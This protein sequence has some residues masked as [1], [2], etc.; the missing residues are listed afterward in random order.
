MS[1]S[2]PPP[3]KINPHSSAESVYKQWVFKSAISR[4][5]VCNNCSSEATPAGKLYVQQAGTIPQLPFKICVLIVKV[6][7]K[8]KLTFSYLV[9]FEGCPD[10]E[11]DLGCRGLGNVT[12]S[13]TWLVAMD[14]LGNPLNPL[15]VSSLKKRLQSEHEEWGNITQTWP[16]SSFIT[17]KAGFTENW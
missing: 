4:E 2:S 13:S 16:G 9:S 10:W 8:G 1:A 5:Q 17:S 12:P 3:K 11:P 15:W 14:C 7:R 6:N